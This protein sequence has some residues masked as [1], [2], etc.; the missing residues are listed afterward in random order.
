MESQYHDQSAAK[1]LTRSIF[2]RN[3]LKFAKRGIPTFPLK[4][5]QPLTPHG[6]KDATTDPRRLHLWGNRYPGA[7]IG[8]PT[9][10]V[11]GLVVVDRDGDSDQAS[12]IWD[13][14]P[15]TVEVAT[16]RGRHRYYSV[17]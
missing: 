10:G 2:L 1:P 12:Q 3:A 4:D 7:N 17:P 9:G 14:L 5:K 6:F 16:S 13:S 11:S 8:I 15:P